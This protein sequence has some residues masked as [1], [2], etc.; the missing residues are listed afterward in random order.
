MF[1]TFIWNACKVRM[2]RCLAISRLV[3]S[4][5]RFNCSY[6]TLFG[7]TY[8]ADYMARSWPEFLNSFYLYN[9]F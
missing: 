2:P 8:F 4:F 3:V 6:P 5:L 1:T 7:K 9:D